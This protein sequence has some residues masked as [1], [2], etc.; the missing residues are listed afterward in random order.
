VT[1]TELM[2]IYTVGFKKDDGNCPV[3]LLFLNL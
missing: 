3:F 2:K 1:I